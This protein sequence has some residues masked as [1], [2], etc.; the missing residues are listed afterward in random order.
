MNAGHGPDGLD[1]AAPVAGILEDAV[2]DYTL[3]FTAKTFR[4]DPAVTQFW[5]TRMH[6]RLQDLSRDDLLRSVV[7]LLAGRASRAAY[8]LAETVRDANPG[9]LLDGPWSTPC[10]CRHCAGRGPGR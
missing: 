6:T 4:L 1:N 3:W 7:T 9:D 10:T 2:D 8:E 5:A